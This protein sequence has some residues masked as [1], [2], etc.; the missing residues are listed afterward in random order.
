MGEVGVGVMGGR[1]KNGYSF[2]CVRE[3]SNGGNRE[4]CRKFSFNFSV[5]FRCLK[6]GRIDDN[7]GICNWRGGRYGNSIW[8]KVNG[9]EVFLE[10]VDFF[11][12]KFCIY[13]FIWF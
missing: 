8:I 9:V 3:D 10:R 11:G 13:S 6:N 5:E 7:I 12:L 4:I 1:Y 2:I